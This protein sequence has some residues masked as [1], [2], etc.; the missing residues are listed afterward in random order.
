MMKP[1][2]VAVTFALAVLLLAGCGGNGDYVNAPDWVM[3]LVRQEAARLGEENPT[4]DFAAC[5][6]STCIVRVFGSFRDGDARAPRLDLEVSIPERSIQ[7]RVF[8][9]DA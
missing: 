2:D 5:G 3:T 8:Y 4:V 6:P 9:Y 1:R 7:E